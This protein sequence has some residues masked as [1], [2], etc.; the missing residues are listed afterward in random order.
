MGERS[1]NMYILGYNTLIY[2]DL[3]S[4][5]LSLL[6]GERRGKKFIVCFIL[7]IINTNLPDFFP[8]FPLTPGERRVTY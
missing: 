5:L 1:L 2:K 7:N 8:F 4:K 3:F 6:A